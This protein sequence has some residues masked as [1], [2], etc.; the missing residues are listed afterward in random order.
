MG[1]RIFVQ[2]Q[3]GQLASLEE[4]RFSS[5][6]ELQA[7]LA[8]RP[9][10]LDGEQMN[11]D[12][13][14]RW[15]VVAREQGIAQAAGEG[16]WWSVDHLLVD[17]DAIPT[18]VEV[19]RGANS[20]V[21]RTVVGQMLEYAA[22]ARLS[23]NADGMRR[24]FEDTVRE[25]D[26]PSQEVLGELLQSDSELDADAFWQ[27]V[28]TNLDAVR[29]RLLIVADDIPSPLK[30]I[31]EF[32]DSQMPNV[33]VRTVEIKRYRNHSMQILVPRVFG[34]ST[35]GSRTT[36]VPTQRLTREVFLDEFPDQTTREAAIRLLDIA[37]DKGVVNWGQ[38]SVAIKAQCSW[39]PFS[40][41][42]L[43]PPSRE[44]LGWYGTKEF[45]FGEA[46]TEYY[47]DLDANLRTA[48]G[49]WTEQF[50]TDPFAEKV[51]TKNITAWSINHDDA[52]AHIDVLAERLAHVLTRLSSL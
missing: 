5:E 43:Y 48:L 16:D 15:M 39:R 24:A 33:E 19:K 7:L 40:I 23:W 13:P 20:E 4:E 11:P 44:G 25:G 28:A 38:T 30:Q 6:D 36:S 51:M 50:R 29:L 22:H 2:D 12:A 47:P 34:G 14:R 18:L 45:T 37:E 41:A 31:A 27:K 8:A 46:V 35:K 21:R 32:L 49:Q 3:E 1:E 26:R 10:L 9:E 42:W 17:Q 52:V